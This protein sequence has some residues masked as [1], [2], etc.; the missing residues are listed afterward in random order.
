MGIRPYGGAVSPE[1]CVLMFNCRYLR[2]EFL[3]F[4]FVPGRLIWIDELKDA[5][6]V[7]GFGRNN[8]TNRLNVQAAT[9]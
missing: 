5:R 3:R 6:E 9:L 2:V 4:I 7:V 1:R 8:K